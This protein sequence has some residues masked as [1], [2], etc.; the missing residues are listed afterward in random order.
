MKTILIVEDNEKSL[1]MIKYLIEYNNYKVI[2]SRNGVDAVKMAA[3][4]KPD[5]ILMD[6][7]LP[8]LDGYNA[9]RQIKANKET[10]KIPIIAVSSF[11]M[12]GDKEKTFKA[13]CNGYI[14]K[15]INPETF[16]TEIEQYF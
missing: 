11:A 12:I 6:I 15:P 7:Q 2:V 8:L 1:Y 16:I 13:G 4:K 9:T 5:L 3:K 10:C 14:E